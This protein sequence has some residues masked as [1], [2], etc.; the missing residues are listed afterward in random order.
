MIFKTEISF[1]LGLI[2]LWT[3]RRGCKSWGGKQETA[4]SCYGIFAAAAAGNV[5]V[6]DDHRTSYGSVHALSHVRHA[7]QVQ[8]QVS[9]MRQS[10]AAGL[11][12]THHSHSRRQATTSSSRFTFD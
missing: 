6:V 8:P 11:R 2:E 7:R 5:I 1:V 3:Q 4:S 12:R 10:R 9:P